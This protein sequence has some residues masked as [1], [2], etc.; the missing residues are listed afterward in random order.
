M[1][2]EQIETFCLVPHG[3]FDEGPTQTS[4]DM[5]SLW[6]LGLRYVWIREADFISG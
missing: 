5:G 4:V 2:P 3:G 1:M 6:I